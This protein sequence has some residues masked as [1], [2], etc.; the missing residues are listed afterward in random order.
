MV[1]ISGFAGLALTVLFAGLFPGTS[2]NAQSNPN[3]GF[4][5][6]SIHK[7]LAVGALVGVAAV[8]GVGITYLVLHNRGVAVGCVTESGGKKILVVSDKKVYSLLGTGPTPPVGERVKLKGHHSG[9][10][11]APSFQIEKVLKDYG[12]CQA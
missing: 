11:S 9:S 10:S 5:V 1:R 12:H 8:A 7:G 6:G 3:S 2:A 4:G